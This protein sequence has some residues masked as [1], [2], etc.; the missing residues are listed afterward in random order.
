MG[1]TY[2]YGMGSKAD[3]ISYRVRDWSSHR[4]IDGESVIVAGKCLDYSVRGR[5]LWTV[6]ETTQTRVN[7]F[8]PF[9]THRWIG[10]DLISK[11][12]SGYGYKDMD[13]SVHPYYYDCPLKFL[14]MVP[15]V[16]SQDWRD[17]VLQFHA[18]KKA[19]GKKK[20]TIKVG[21]TLK[22]VNTTIPEVIVVAKQGS[23]I[24]GV[25]QGRVY[26]VTPRFIGEVVSA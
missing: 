24:Q 25:Y 19:Q 9:A 12:S 15:E 18:A 23:K 13:E 10:L 6:W 22:L 26:R 7:E 4:E 2:P 3:M 17:G 20:A 5:C 21:D 16:A 11:D 8:E 1:W 14:D